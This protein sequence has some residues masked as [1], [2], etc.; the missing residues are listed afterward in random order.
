ML[1]AQLESNNRVSELRTD[2]CLVMLVNLGHA[3]HRALAARIEVARK[4]ERRT[5]REVDHRTYN[6]KQDRFLWRHVV[7]AH[8]HNQILE[9]LPIAARLAFE[10]DT[11]DPRQ[12]DESEVVLV[13]AE[14][15]ERDGEVAHVFTV[16]RQSRGVLVNF[17]SYFVERDALG[18]LRLSD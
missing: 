12:I 16:A 3:K 1:R 13:M 2:A 5:C 11:C 17:Q 10:R 15:F 6:V 8:L 14:N 4:L 9:P 18:R 7:V